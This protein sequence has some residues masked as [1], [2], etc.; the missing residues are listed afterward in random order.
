[1]T[2]ALKIVELGDPILFKKSAPIPDVLHPDIQTLIDQMIE[3]LKHANGVGLAAPQVG[4]SKRLYLVWPDP[5]ATT[6][7]DIR[8]VINPKLTQLPSPKVRDIEGCLSIPGMRGTVSRHQLVQLQYQDRT[9]ETHSVTLR[10]FEARIVQHEH[11]HL[12]GI[13]YLDRISST[14]DLMTEGYYTR[15][16]ETL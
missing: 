1:M 12:D 6:A 10:D 5:V 16:E 4:V 15:M 14:Q 2:K 3:T 13:V 8:I 9:G 11:D 7:A